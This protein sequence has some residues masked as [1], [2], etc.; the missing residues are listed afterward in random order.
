MHPPATAGGTD[1]IQV[2]FH[3][4]STEVLLRQCLPA[5]T[6]HSCGAAQDPKW[7]NQK[8]DRVSEEGRLIS[9]DRVSHELQDPTGDEQQQR[10]TPVE[11]EERQRDDNHRYPDA[12]REPVQRVLVL[13]FVVG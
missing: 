11:E 10:P 6:K 5:E 1:C 7:S 12:V 9:L 4:L 3:I 13:R 2:R 8:I